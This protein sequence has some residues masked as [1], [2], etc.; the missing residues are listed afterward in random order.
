MTIYIYIENQFPALYRTQPVRLLTKRPIF[1]S[2]LN[3]QI[4][5]YVDQM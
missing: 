4:D 1:E 2:S 3:K 5:F